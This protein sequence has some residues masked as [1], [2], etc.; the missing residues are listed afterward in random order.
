VAIA[1]AIALAVAAPALAATRIH[2]CLRHDGGVVYQDEACDTGQ[3]L[4]RAWTTPPDPAVLPST[5]GASRPSGSR[6]RARTAARRASRTV[7]ASDPCREAKER[8]DA[9]ERRV[10]LARTYELLSALQRDVYDA[11]R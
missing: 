4:L 7:P 6:R 8:R 10:G 3:R 2:A 5:P 1:I 9:I 11:C